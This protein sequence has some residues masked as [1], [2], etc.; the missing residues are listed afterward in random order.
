MY[1]IGDKIGPKNLE[2]LDRK[3]K[4]GKFECPSC[5][6][7]FWSSVWGISSGNCQSCGCTR[8]IN[9]G[10]PKK[11]LAGKVFGELTVLEDSGRRASCGA[12]I[13]KCQCSCGNIT[14][15]SSSDLGR[16][17]RT[18]T[19]S[20]GHDRSKGEQKVRHILLEQNINF[21]QE[22]CFK[23]CINPKTG[24]YLRF[25]FYL[26]DYNCCIEYDGKQHFEEIGL[27]EE[28][29]EKTQYRDSIK[30][31]YCKDKGILLV[32]I[33]YFDYKKIDKEYILNRIEQ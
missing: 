4:L 30:N 16:K 7:I 17:A 22:K 2:I 26:P 21:I 32:R 14:Y 3:D 28:N 10:Q 13:W 12:V 11:E 29:L 9:A 31:K 1:H 5:G 27:I 20:C 24:M 23:D 25:D 6:K 33:P 19:K 15:V 8:K 18:G